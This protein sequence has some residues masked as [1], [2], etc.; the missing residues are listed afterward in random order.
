MRNPLMLIW[1]RTST[2]PDRHTTPAA[3][4]AP[5]PSH[6]RTEATEQ[7]TP[8]TVPAPADE[9]AQTVTATPADEPEQ[10]RTG[11]RS[12]S[13]AVTVP[14]IPGAPSGTVT[15]APVRAASTA[16][17]CTRPAAPSVTV[18]DGPARP[19]RG[20]RL[21]RFGDLAV[22][23][24]AVTVTLGVA[25]AAGIISVRHF[26]GL[27]VSLGEP[28]GQAILYPAAAEGMVVMASLVMLYVSRRGLRVPWLAWVAL[29][30]GIAVSLIVNVVHGLANGRGAA[31]LAALAPLAFVASYELLMILI[32]LVRQAASRNAAA[33]VCPAPERVEVPTPVPVWVVRTERVPVE[34][35]KPVEVERRI[36]VP[37][38]VERRVEVPVP[39]VPTDALDAA[40]IAF[41]HSLKSPG[42]T[43]GQRTLAQRF[44]IPYATAAEIIRTSR[45]ALDQTHDGPA[46]D[47]PSVTAVEPADDTVTDEQAGQPVEHLDDEPA[48][49][50]PDTLDDTVT[51][52]DDELTAVTS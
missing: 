43:L 37:I 48:V 5:T 9:P 47:E 22:L 49:T 6:S 15:V 26:V 31:A 4:A 20:S 46:D 51:A 34:V 39:V 33:H 52:D 29:A 40:R 38:P 23:A 16:T 21:D 8:V 45:E 11:S 10:T 24:A 13:L 36:T 3:E 18:S 17:G 7:H 42:R 27:A 50:V 1:R 30:F 32:R 12:P 44:G 25:I 14:P 41:E 19:S 2:A 28:V 35:P